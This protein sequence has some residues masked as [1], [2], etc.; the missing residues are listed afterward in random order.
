[1]SVDLIACRFCVGEQTKCE[2]IV[3]V[4]SIFNVFRKENYQ[5][6]HNVAGLAFLVII[7]K[8]II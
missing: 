4:C 1:M 3:V 6:F 8:T 7:L 5:N 2:N